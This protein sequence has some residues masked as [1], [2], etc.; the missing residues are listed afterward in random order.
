MKKPL[1]EEADVNIK[2]EARGKTL[3][4]LN[5]W[6]R[7]VNI[8]FCILNVAR[9]LSKGKLWGRQYVKMHLQQCSVNFRLKQLKGKRCV[10]LDKER[11]V[12][13]QN[14]EVKSTLREGWELTLDCYEKGVDNQLFLAFSVQA[15]PNFVLGGIMSQLQNFMNWVKNFYELKFIS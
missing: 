14:M 2:L 1:V 6:V 3:R 5:G 12:K 13:H 7:T 9:S 11:T 10:G 8:L 4:I 15:L